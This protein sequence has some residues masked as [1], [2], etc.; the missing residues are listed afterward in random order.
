MMLLNSLQNFLL[1][2]KDLVSSY[3]WFSDTLDII[4]VALLVYGIIVSLRKSQSIQIIKGLVLVVIIYGIVTL[5]EMK[6]S[7]YIF[8]KFFGDI[9]ILFVIIFSAEIRKA[10]ESVGKKKF[11]FFTS[12]NDDGNLEAVNAVCRA[13]GAMSASKVGSLI[14]FQR[15]SF[16]GDLSKGAVPID[17]ETTYEMICSIFYPNAPLHD[18][19]VIIKDGRIVAARCVVPM[20][21]DREVTDNIGTRHRA[22]MEVSANSD[23]VAVVTSEETGIISI[24]VN[25]KLERGL[26]DSELNEKLGHLLLTDRKTRGEKKKF[27]A[28]K[29]KKNASDTDTENEEASETENSETTGGEASDN[30]LDT[31]TSVPDFSSILANE[32]EENDEQE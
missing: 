5:L 4:F 28:K 3:D 15:N 20:T 2:L 6:T 8:A 11:S 22:A 1:Q 29:D 32:G 16:L 14:V 7:S 10:L 31:P 25:G 26:T 27:G 23:A 9:I 19:A 21:N 13:C 30:Y 17:A 18:G 12:D 24:A